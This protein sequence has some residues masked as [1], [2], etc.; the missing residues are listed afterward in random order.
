MIA[1]KVIEANLD[2]IHVLSSVE[3]PRNKKEEKKLTS[4]AATLNRFMPR[5]ENRCFLFFKAL[6]GNHNF[7]WTNDSE[8]V[9]QELKQTLASP[10]V[11]TRAD[12]GYTLFLYLAVSQNAVSGVLLKE[13]NKAQ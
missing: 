12:P 8:R 9:F 5:A 6:R 2:K 13:V 1:Y 7:E 10:P 3:S 4:Y 11:L